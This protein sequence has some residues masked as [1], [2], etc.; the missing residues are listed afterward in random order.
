MKKLPLLLFPLA[1]L[2]LIV[3]PSRSAQI[4]F[5]QFTITNL[6]TVATNITDNGTNRSFMRATLIGC[7]AGGVSNAAPVYVGATTNLQ[8]YII[9]PG[10]RHVI[11]VAPPTKGDVSPSSSWWLRTPTTGDGLIVIY[12][13]TP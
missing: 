1:L 5:G 11:E 4:A 13:P 2:A 12:N 8:P 6:H 9:H 7:K 3:L 10:E